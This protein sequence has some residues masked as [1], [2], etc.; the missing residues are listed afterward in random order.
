MNPAFRFNCIQEDGV[1]DRDILFSRLDPGADRNVS[2]R[3]HDLGDIDVIGTSDAAGVTGGADPDRFRP[4][5][6]LPVIVLDMAEDLVGKE[7]HGISHR[8]S[9][10]TLLALIT[11]LNGFAARLMDFR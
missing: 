1:K 4:K 7:I 11:I 3:I 6:F 8:A 10:R 9:C 5:N 2:Q